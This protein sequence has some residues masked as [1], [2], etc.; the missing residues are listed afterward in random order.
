MD[1]DRYI[2][3]LD[4]L[5]VDVEN[6]LGRKVMDGHDYSSSA[7]SAYDDGYNQGIGDALDTFVE[8][9]KEAVV[10]ASDTEGL[11]RL[12]ILRYRL[13]GAELV[14]VSGDGGFGGTQLVF[15]NG[16]SIEV[17]HF[18]HREGDGNGQG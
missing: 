13:L 1:I 15:S 18:S 6:G 2:A 4:N 11:D 9:L 8:K 12:D 10:N 14:E 7:Y 16:D 5:T 3:L 17:L